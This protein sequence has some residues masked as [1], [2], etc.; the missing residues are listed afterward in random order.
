M[1][2]E[3]WTSDQNQEEVHYFLDND[4]ATYVFGYNPSFFTEEQIKAILTDCKAKTDSVQYENTG[5]TRKELNM[6]VWRNFL[7][8]LL[9]YVT[10]G[11]F[12]GAKAVANKEDVGKVFND[13]LDAAST[14][15][16]VV[17]AQEEIINETVRKVGK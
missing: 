1:K 3:K 9:P 7:V 13:T 17:A 12:K 14:D 10:L 4:Q 2:F 11:L 15:P 6:S 8:T 16:K 5:T